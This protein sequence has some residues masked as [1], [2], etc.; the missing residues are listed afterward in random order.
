MAGAFK[1]ISFSDPGNSTAKMGA[2]S[3]N[4]QKA[5]ITQVTEIEVSPGYEADR[6]GREVTELANLDNLILIC[7]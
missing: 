5:S 2:F 3:G 6:A 4:S 7:C 1:L